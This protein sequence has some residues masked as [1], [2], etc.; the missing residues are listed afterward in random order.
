MTPSNISLPGVMEWSGQ[1][2]MVNGHRESAA[3]GLS[4]LLHVE[5]HNS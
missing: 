4:S 1:P 5:E 2:D 3:T